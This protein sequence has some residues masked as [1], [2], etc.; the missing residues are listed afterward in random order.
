MG[1][2]VHACRVSEMLEV[3]EKADALHTEAALQASM[4]ATHSE[5]D[6]SLIAFRE[7]RARACS[8]QQSPCSSKHPATA[9]V[10]RPALLVA[11]SSLA[12]ILTWLR[13]LGRWRIPCSLA[14][15]CW[16]RA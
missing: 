7:V 5:A 1:V 3:V 4:A 14:I 12:A 11:L 2:L 6:D 15:A 9:P 16:C 13:R 10:A 8:T